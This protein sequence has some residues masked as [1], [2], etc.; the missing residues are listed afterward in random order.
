[1]LQ[2]ESRG[3][4]RVSTIDRFAIALPAAIVLGLCLAAYAALKS[5]A[6]SGL[7][8]DEVVLHAANVAW[9]GMPLGY[10][11]RVLMENDLPE[12]VLVFALVCAWSATHVGEL[13]R[14]ALRRRVLL[15]VVAFEPT[16]ALTR[17][18]Q[19]HGS[20]PRP[21]SVVTLM[22]LFGPVN[23]QRSADTFQGYSSF[24]SD[25][26]ALSAIA[27]V[28][29]FSIDRRYGWFFTILG[30]YVNAYR[31]AYGLHW[32]SDVVGGIFIG[33]AVAATLLLVRPWLRRPFN[34]VLAVFGRHPAIA[35]GCAVLF[36]SEF[37]HGFG[38]VSA[39]VH[40]LGHGRLFH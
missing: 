5:L 34:A 11:Q 1:M 15:A 4:F 9:A 2:T 21:A 25:H 35:T 13:D 14:M 22:P 32:P 31:I 3:G 24:P 36:L 38:R 28:V 40:A 6:P 8:Y 23:W 19:A 16:Y 26:A 17:F 37:G 18:V 27:A 7:S 29:A 10:V 30:L 12:L 20:E 39:V 33:T